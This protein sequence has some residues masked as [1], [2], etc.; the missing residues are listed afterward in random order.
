[1]W[2][3]PIFVTLLALTPLSLAGKKCTTTTTTPCPTVTTTAEICSTCI[4]KECLALSTISNPRSCPRKIATVTTSYPCAENTCPDGCASTSY[5]YASTYGNP[6]PTITKKPACPTVTSVLGRCSTCVMPMCMALST[7][8]SECGCPLTAA[9]VTTSYAC[10][11]KCP[12]GCAGTE[13][14]Y[15]TVTP[16]CKGYPAAV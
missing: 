13:Y 1:M 7:I 8:K 10:D 16:D 6:R 9:T 15:D 3:L 14:V 12:G 11:G 4:L 2:S 5:I